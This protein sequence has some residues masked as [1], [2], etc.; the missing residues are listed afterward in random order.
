MVL[1]YCLFLAVENQTLAIFEMFNVGAS[2]GYG[3]TSQGEY[4]PGSA[5]I[6]LSFPEKS[7]SGFP[8][9]PKLFPF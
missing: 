3:G 7:F 9:I 5:L 2:R 1:Q 6:K 8:Q 4:I